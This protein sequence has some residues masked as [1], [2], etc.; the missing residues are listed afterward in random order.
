M[1]PSDDVLG[2]AAA[3]KPWVPGAPAWVREQLASAPR[4][5]RL[6]LAELLPPRVPIDVSPDLGLAWFPA[7]PRAARGPDAGLFAVEVRAPEAEGT[8]GEAAVLAWVAALA[9]CGPEELAVS[10]LTVRGVPDGYALDGASWG[11]AGAVAVI[12]YLLAAAPR[13]P[14][15][16]SG[17]VGAPGPVPRWL[18]VEGEDAK[19]AAVEREAGGCAFRFVT[20]PTDALPWLSSWFGEDWQR[21]LQASLHR[22]P[23]TL[24]RRAVALYRQGQHTRAAGVAGAAL[25]GGAAGV[26]GGLALW[27]RGSNALHRG[28]TEEG[29]ED[30]RHAAER[31]SEAP[32]HVEHG[33]RCTH[34]ELLASIGVAMLDA[35]RAAQ[36]VAT[37]TE[38]RDGLLAMPATLRTMPGW[39]RA[40]VHVSGSL[41]R[42]RVLAGDLEGALEVLTHPALGVG[43]VAQEA[44][45]TWGD[46]AEVHRR[47]GRVEEAQAALDKGWTC[48]P[49]VQEGERGRTRR[50]LELYRV[51]AGLS[52]PPDACRPA[53]RWPWP[54]LGFTLE[55]LLQEDPHRITEWILT[56]GH[57]PPGR[58]HRMLLAGFGARWVARSG[59]VPS[60][61]VEV[62]GPL[63]EDEEIDEEV[64]GALRELV[65]GRA[66]AWIRRSPY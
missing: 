15:V 16:V 8:P 1:C 18:P 3:L 46:V 51:R 17:A 61:L 30:L 40:W 34:A 45:R 14:V 12:S 33:D 56:P 54:E 7:V 43:L 21:R 32:E 44:A 66:E 35:G 41:H 42:A 63:V 4:L 23:E 48:L 2:R 38:T 50:F 5:E 39:R 57:E 29:F 26:A 60:W 36:A 37:L 65:G 59:R 49:D 47:C 19:R 52:E 53:G 25:G 28:R 31:L 10:G 20:G 62:V 9:G 22:S 24:A 6:I 27:V 55:R 64:R 11:A 13:S 58:V